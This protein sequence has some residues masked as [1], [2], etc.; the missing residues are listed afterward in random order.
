MGL[1]DCA[2]AG[3]L[4][5]IG[6]SRPAA[7]GS[8]TTT[9][10]TGP[11]GGKGAGKYESG[12]DKGSSSSGDDTAIIVVI[13]A[14]LVLLAVAAAGGAFLFGKQMPHS[15]VAAQHEA[16]AT[17]DNPVY[18]DPTF[19]PNCNGRTVQRPPILRHAHARA[20]ASAVAA[21]VCTGSAGG[22]V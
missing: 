20:A 5:T 6:A 8:Y 4:P 14:L 11:A 16:R 21:Q 22:Y 3:G 2:N 9:A 12:A 1:G 15:D 18:V 10:S 17:H 19:R 7:S 13:V